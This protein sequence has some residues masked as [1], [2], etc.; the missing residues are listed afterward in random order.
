MRLSCLFVCCVFLIGSTSVTTAEND[1]T[2]GIKV[3]EMVP[4]FTL[5]DQNG[6]EYV[7][8]DM[9]GKGNV[10]LVFHRSADW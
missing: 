8:T 5:K 1:E 10:A 2:P 7:L 9:L 3:G 4:A 6:K